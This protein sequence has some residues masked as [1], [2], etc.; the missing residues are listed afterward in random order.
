[1]IHVV[2]PN[3]R[4]VPRDFV[5]QG[6]YSNAKD[7]AACLVHCSL[8]RLRIVFGKAIGGTPTYWNFVF[9]KVPPGMYFL[10]ISDPVRR[11]EK[12]LRITVLGPARKKRKRLGVLLDPLPAPTFPQPNTTIKQNF[13]AFGNAPSNP[14][15]VISG[16]MQ[17]NNGGL[18]MCP[19]PGVP[20]G[21]PPS[22]ANDFL[23]ALEFNGVPLAPPPPDPNPYRLHVMSTQH[24]PTDVDSL[25]IGP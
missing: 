9:T 1:V 20:V 17:H 13:T 2:Y 22:A 7:L 18:P 10:V 6:D 8:T 19:F 3:K 21:D 4:S 11:V 12:R 15:P 16:E 25:T 24:S 14:D 23:W 5:A